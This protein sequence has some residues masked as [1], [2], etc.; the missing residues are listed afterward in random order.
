[1][2]FNNH[3]V[4]GLKEAM[5]VYMSE[6]CLKFRPALE[7]DPYSV[8]IRDGGWGCNAIVGQAG[9]KGAQ[10]LNL[11]D[12]CRFYGLFLHELGHTIGLHHEHQ[13]PDRGTGVSVNMDNVEES[14][15]QWFE[16]IDPSELNMYGVDYDIQSIMHYEETAFA[17]TGADGQKKITIVAKKPENQRYLYHV[18]MKDLSFGDAKRI[19]L[20]YKCNSH[21]AN[22]NCPNGFVNK[23]CQCETP[24]AFA[25]RRCVNNYAESVCESR[26]KECNASHPSELYDVFV[27]CRKTC[28]RCYEAI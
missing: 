6:T 25:K 3:E 24:Q 4:K 17:A 23:H 5:D 14:M 21:C 11:A 7:S 2:A 13:H 15:R 18:Y 28:N 27:N 8:I 10:T 26:K 22:V 19:N 1:M 12:G 16:L 20:M 9:I